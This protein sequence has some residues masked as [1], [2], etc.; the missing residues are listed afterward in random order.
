MNIGTVTK[1]SGWALFVLIVI[2]IITGF[3]YAGYLGLDGIIPP[4]TAQSIHNNPITAGILI[5]L[6]IIHAFGR[7]LAGL[8]NRSGKGEKPEVVQPA[9]Q[10]PQ[11][12]PQQPKEE[13]QLQ[14]HSEQ[15]QQG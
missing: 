6:I 4:A 12:Q 8:R 7:T 5:I 13:P 15:P 9:P 3:S 10:Q 11:S 1:Y 2:L 14:S